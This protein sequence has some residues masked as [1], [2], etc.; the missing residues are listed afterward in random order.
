MKLFFR[1]FQ[2]FF[3]L[4]LTLFFFMPAINVYAGT[5]YISDGKEYE[6]GYIIIGESH[7]VVSS[8]AY[9]RYTDEQNHVIGLENVNYS[10][11]WDSSLFVDENGHANTFTMS[12][13]LFFVFEGNASADANKQKSKEYIFS[14]GKGNC[15]LGVQKIHEIINTNPN[16]SHWNIISYHGAVSALYGLQDTEYYISSYKNWMSYEFPDA[17]LFFVSHS[18]ITKFYKQNRNAY[19]FDEAI[20]NAFPSQYFD[21][22]SF[23]KQRYP[24]EMYDPT[25]NPDTIHW[26][27]KT[28]VELFNYVINRINSE[29]YM[30]KCRLQ[31][32]RLQSEQYKYLTN[33]NA[34]Y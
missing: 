4:M 5:V 27:H 19:Q 21:M 14:D 10:F 23:Y 13:N 11:C 15:G 17:S 30:E 16:I 33:K 12:G 22:N 26:N 7:A 32:T 8:D 29:A 25:M 1:L 34:C 24:Q 18:T 2:S 31:R 3:L 28:Y 9:S 20:K 6:E